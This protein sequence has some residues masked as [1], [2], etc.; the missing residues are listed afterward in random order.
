V[1]D[2]RRYALV[3]SLVALEVEAVGGSIAAIIAA[4]DPTAELPELPEPLEVA[5]VLV[6]TPDP[7][8]A[9]YIVH[10]DGAAAAS[11]AEAEADKAGWSSVATWAVLDWLRVNAFGMRPADL[12]G[13]LPAHRRPAPPTAA[14]TPSALAP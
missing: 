2:R 4:G 9:G 1:P 13:A 8:S 6:V 12:P 11:P 10:R 5:A 7:P 3:F 14:P